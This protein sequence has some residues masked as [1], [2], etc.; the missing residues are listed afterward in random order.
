MRI[1]ILNWRD[2]KNPQGG[3]AEILTHEM[4]KRWA[5][6]GHQVIQI[7]AGFPGA[8]KEESIEGV[9][10]IRLGRWWNVHLFAFF[11]YWRNLREKVDIIVDEVHWTPFFSVLYSR[12]KIV[13]LVCEVANKLFFKVFPYPLAVIGRLIEKI[14]L[15]LYKD[16]ATLVI[17]PSTKKDLIK[18]GFKEEKIT[19]IPMGLSTP[20]NL[21]IYHRERKPTVIYLGRINKQKG[22]EDAIA[23]FNLVKQKLPQSQFWIVGSGK[24][25][26]VQKIKNKITDLKLPSV[27]FFGFV[28]EREKYRLLSKAHLLVVPSFHEGWG[29]IV[30]EAGFVGT[31]AIVYNVAGLRDVVQNNYN[32]KVVATNPQDMA[33]ACLTLLSDSNRYQNYCLNAQKL[34]KK[35]NWEVTAQIALKFL[36]KYR[37]NNEKKASQFI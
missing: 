32:G 2:I 36:K 34:A 1:L 17:S 33:R 5:K 12:K 14:Y 11:Y 28:S 35:Y 20:K 31:P 26:Y 9:K 22:I 18:E 23:A 21:K 19:I 3:G 30:P 29:L 6:W 13:L 16:M 37:R 27:K 7:S 15:Y 25:E 4:A 8:E 10:I 24:K